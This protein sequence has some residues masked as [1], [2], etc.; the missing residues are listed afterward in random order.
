MNKTTSLLFKQTTNLFIV[1]SNGHDP[2]TTNL[3]CGR[4][5][6]VLSL[7]CHL[8]TPLFSGIP[9]GLRSLQTLS[10]GFLCLLC[11]G[12]H[13]FDSATC[14]PAALVPVTSV[15][16]APLLPVTD[17]AQSVSQD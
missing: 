5:A 11:K 12:S 15:S 7:L 4:T 3:Y 16:Q 13:P 10:A 1:R 17:T 2:D 8:R 14:R 9:E 6:T